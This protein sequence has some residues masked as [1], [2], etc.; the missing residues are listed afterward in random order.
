MFDVFYSGVKPDLFAHE[1][2]AR[3]IEHAR[4]QSRTRDFWWVNYLSDYTGWD[5]LWEPVP[6]EKQFTHTWPSQ[7][8]EYSGTYLVPTDV[9]TIEYKFHTEIIPNRNLQ[10][11]YQVVVPGAEFDF[12]WH[13]HPFDPPYIYVFGNQWRPANKMATVEYHAPGATERKYMTLAARLPERHTNHWHTVIDCDWDYSW[14]PDPGDPPYIYVFGNQWHRAEVMPTV[15]Y[16]VPGATERK[17][18]L[19]PRAKLVADMLHWTVPDNTNQEAFDF[20]WLPD[21]GSPAYIY[22]FGTQWN[23]AGGPVYTV[24]GATEIKYTQAQIARMLPTD[25]NW[26]IPEGIDINSFDFSWTPDSTEQPYKYEFGTQWQ[27]TGGPVYTVPGATET[28]YIN[29]P[30]SAKAS[31]DAFWE[32]PA[33]ADVKSFDWTWHPDATDPPYIYQFGTQHQRTGGPRYY[34][35][36]ATE[37]KYVDQIK[38]ITKRVATAIYEIDHLDGNA[39][40]TANIT[41]TSRYFDNYLDTLKRIAKSVPDEHEFVWICSSVCDYTDFDFTW[42][43][44][45]WQATM[46]HVFPSDGEKFGDTF[47]MHV[48]TFLYRSEKCQLLEWYDLNFTDISVPRRPI[49]VI[50]HTYDSQATAAKSIE[51]QG[52][53]AVFTTADCTVDTI[54]TVPLWR[55]KTKTIVPISTGAASV[56]VPRAAI[57]YIKTQLYD[58]PYIDKTQRTIKDNALDIVFISNGEPNAEENWSRLQRVVKDMPNRL[59]RIDGINGRVAAYQAALSASH[60]SWAFCVFAKL[61]VDFGFDWAWQPDRMQEPKHYIFHAMNPVNSLVYGHMAVIAYNKQLVMEN[62]ATG[63]DFTLDQAHEVVPM[64]SGVAYY[65]DSAWMAW[66]TAFREVIKLK[67]SLPDVEAEYRLSKWLTV[68]SSQSPYSK[69]SII[70]AQDA[71]EYYDSVAGNFVDLRKSYDWAWLSSYAFVKHSL[72]PD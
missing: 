70:G 14:V 9:D 38:I 15:E 54:P 72:S 34:V 39:G 60:T 27:K 41:K 49:P 11:H 28:K 43:P 2:E 16:H 3:D 12:S 19:F 64:L 22:Q 26:I 36:G 23:R 45:Q 69:W 55:E 4:S 1:L 48:P 29:T 37:T 68:N 5:F 58:Y 67:N 46:L 7:H 18:L 59:V 47:F 50:S 31:R 10:E 42:H 71:V 52:P 25:L 24:P 30:R 62:T 57:P 6:W 61:A 51:F 8:H 20:T 17:Y 63:L 56:I 65:C 32:I 53:L 35:P 13:P 40:Q 66:R 33:G 44:E 21:P